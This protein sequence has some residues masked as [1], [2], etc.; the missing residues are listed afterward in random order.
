MAK[1]SQSTISIPASFVHRIA[2]MGRLLVSLADD[3]QA[4]R[5][6]VVVRR[7]PKN[8]PKDQEW[9]WSKQWQKWERQA[10][11]EMARGEFKEFDS[12]EELIAD[13]HSH[14]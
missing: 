4:H 6:G 14:I 12:V 3:L 7:K 8:V 5:S 9:Y 13:L 10:D 2:A 11:E 1:Q